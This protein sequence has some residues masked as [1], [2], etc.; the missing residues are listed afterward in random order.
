MK[1]IKD[2]MELTPQNINTV[3]YEAFKQHMLDVLDELST[4]I[5]KG[6]LEEVPVF[7]SPS[8]DCMGRDN[9]CIDFGYEGNYCMDISEAF[10]LLNNLQYQVKIPK[11]G[12]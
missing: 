10:K 9:V 1:N 11:K 3:K 4:A 7:E 5:K 8:G 6:S 2:I 12:E